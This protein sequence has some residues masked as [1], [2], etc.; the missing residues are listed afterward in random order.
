MII[1]SA[2][3][4]SQQHVTALLT[5]ATILTSP[6][7]V[8]S[9]RIENSPFVVMPVLS[10]T[11]LDD[12]DIR[13]MQSY[14][15]GIQRSC[16]MALALAIISEMRNGKRSKILINCSAGMNRSATL[17]CVVIST[18]QR[19]NFSDAMTYLEKTRA[20]AHQAGQMVP[21]GYFLSSGGA[22]FRQLFIADSQIG[23]SRSQKR[24]LA[25]ASKPV[26]SPTG[27]SYDMKRD[28]YTLELLECDKTKTKLY[29]GNLLAAQQPGFDLVVDL[30]GK[31]KTD[32][33]IQMPF[34]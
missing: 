10:I 27:P 26:S 31:A 11:S 20:E 3:A 9:N 29:I 32:G 5:A 8:P 24:R 18:M 1:H 34:S 25:L 12:E 33:A 13:L 22:Y 28:P 2:R 30:S 14:N 19:I 7:L 16:F 15:F 21:R 23:L 17:A 6:Y 4:T